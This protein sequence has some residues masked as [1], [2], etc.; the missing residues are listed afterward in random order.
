MRHSMRSKNNPFL[1]DVNG[2]LVQGLGMIWYVRSLAKRY[3][4]G[5]VD[6]YDLAPEGLSKQ[7]EVRL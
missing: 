1:G 5:I 6:S 3:A 7:V 4:R 2:G